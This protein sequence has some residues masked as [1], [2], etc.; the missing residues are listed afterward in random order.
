MKITS[1][2]LNSN[3]SSLEFS[4]SKHS[5]P[6]LSPRIKA[7]ANIPEET[8]PPRERGDSYNVDEHRER[9]STSDYRD[10][11]KSEDEIEKLAVRYIL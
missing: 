1:D 2:R 8:S 10:R 11:G 5:K 3:S 7:L 9:S 6:M 4:D